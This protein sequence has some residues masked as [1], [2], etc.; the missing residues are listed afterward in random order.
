MMTREYQPMS[1]SYSA[2][3]SMEDASSCCSSEATPG[4]TKGPQF[5]VSMRTSDVDTAP[6]EPPDAVLGSADTTTHRTLST[7]IESNSGLNIT[8]P[9]TT[10]IRR[11][12]TQYNH[13]ALGFFVVFAVTGLPVV[14]I[15]LVT[16]S[17]ATQLSAGPLTVRKPRPRILECHRSSI[18]EAMQDRAAMLCYPPQLDSRQTGRLPAPSRQSPS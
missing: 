4:I 16:F 3:T 9:T 14:G 5:D 6:L 11:K 15:S 7:A 13:S 2:P 1:N 12:P 10:T 17:I 18:P 8:P